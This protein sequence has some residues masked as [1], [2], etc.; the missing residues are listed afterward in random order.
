MTRKLKT[1]EQGIKL[2]ETEMVP[3]HYT[4]SLCSP[5]LGT[6]NSISR[7]FQIFVLIWGARV[8]EGSG[9]DRRV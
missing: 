7:L 9:E 5:S 2:V 3:L 8:G 6:K 1:I 4:F